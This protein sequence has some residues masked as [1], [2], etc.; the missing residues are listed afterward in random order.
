MSRT[1]RFWDWFLTGLICLNPMGAVAYY[2]AGLEA[3][4]E[5][6]QYEPLR[7]GRRATVSG[8]PRRATAVPLAR[9]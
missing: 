4:E 6:P 2:N 8:E 3:G 5:A 1:G 9:L 7:A